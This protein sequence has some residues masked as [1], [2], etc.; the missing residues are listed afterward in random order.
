MDFVEKL[1]RFQARAARSK[2]IDAVAVHEDSVRACQNETPPRSLFAEIGSGRYSLVFLGPEMLTETAFNDLI[3]EDGFLEHLRY[4]TIDECHLTNEWKSFRSS[5]A[6]IV[7]LRNRFPAGLV[8]WLA[9]SATISSRDQPR[10]IK[11]LGFSQDRRRCTIKR[12]PVD[13]LT[14]TYAPRILE[15]SASSFLDLSTLIPLSATKP[16]DIPTTIVFAQRIDFGNRLMT[17]LTNILP[18]TIKGV[19]RRRLILPYNSMM[20]MDF[21]LDAVESLRSGSQTRMLICTDTGAFGIDIAEVEQVVVI[22]TDPGETFETLCQKSGRVRVKGLAI[23]YL[24]RWANEKRMGK[25]DV[26]MRKK[27]QPVMV[28]YAN[29]TRNNCPR[30]VNC[31]YWGEPMRTP[32]E[33]PCCNKH[34]PE[35]DERH[36]KEMAERKKQQKL[37]RSRKTVVRSD[38]THKPLGK[39]LQPAVHQILRQW[40]STTWVLW[41]SRTPMCPPNRLISDELLWQLCKRLH[42]C[43]TMD[44][45]RLV[46]ATWER[47]D[48]FGTSL[49]EFCQRLLVSTDQLYSPPNNQRKRKVEVQV[50]E[51]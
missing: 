7:H 33:V 36:Y 31:R 24:P 44:R 49:Y 51:N 37:V 42:A 17:Y 50:A 43:T 40:R 28:E 15:N 46:L 26:R 22:T 5:Y 20:S 34:C 6:R 19:A 8:V 41:P 29:A 3:H 18:K 25:E 35:V 1:T 2:G 27:A 11:E 48:E 23:A 30:A 38:G 13:R 9:M 32:T 4:F 12:L 47:L 10:F 39:A 21:C 16:G 45:F 14:L